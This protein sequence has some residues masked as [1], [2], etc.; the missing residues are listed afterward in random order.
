[1]GQNLSSPGHELVNGT[2]VPTNGTPSLS[3]DLSAVGF[4]KFP[5]SRYQLKN[6]LF[7]SAM[8]DL[9]A[10]SQFEAEDPRWSHIFNPEVLVELMEHPYSL[11]EF[12]LRL[13]QNNPTSKNL[14]QLMEQV[15][16][17]IRFTIKKKGPLPEHLV[18]QCCMA[19]FLLSALM[20]YF[21]MFQTTDEV[22]AHYCSIS[23]CFVSYGSLFYGLLVTSSCEHSL[24]CRPLG[25]KSH[26]KFKPQ[27]NPSRRQLSA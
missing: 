4:G 18:P 15:I 2:D 19:T 6:A 16:S 20:Q 12:A 25:R 5:K 8:T 27:T 3:L 14:I 11:S 10:R 9:S 7:V 22:I 23:V 24:D 21:F 1:M 13:I 26:C 17:N